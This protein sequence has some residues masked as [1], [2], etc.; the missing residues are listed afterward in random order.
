MHE[1]ALVIWH[2]LF[3]LIKPLYFVFKENLT[4][5]HREGTV[6][7]NPPPQ[8]CVHLTDVEGFIMEIWVTAQ[9]SLMGLKLPVYNSVITYLKT[10]AGQ[11]LAETFLPT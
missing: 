6:S 2:R 10:Y 7:P 8:R 5:V 11:C 3:Q 9:S 1:P 4:R